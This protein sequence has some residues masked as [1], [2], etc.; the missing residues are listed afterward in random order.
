VPGQILAS[1][2]VNTWLVP[3]CAVK[4]ADTPRSSNT[5]L[6]NDPDLTVNFV[7]G[8]TYQFE[9]MLD[10]EGAS[11]GTAGGLSWNWVAPVSIL[12]YTRA[13]VNT[14]A[15]YSFGM[16]TQGGGPY[17]GGTQGAG[18]LMSI[19]MWGIAI[20]NST[21]AMTLQW[22]QGSSSSTA[23]ILHQGS[24]LIAQRVG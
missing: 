24:F 7:N 15:T 23:T 18:T 6:A 17:T 10:Y 22:A 13:L 1:A 8:G 9:C 20:A 21:G 4:P 14:A 19:H 3:Q 5:T 12:R 2:D 11:G 16:S